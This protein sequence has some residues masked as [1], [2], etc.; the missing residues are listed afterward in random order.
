MQAV[1]AVVRRQQAVGI[2][3]ITERGV[4][5]H[6][7]VSE[8]AG[9]DVVVDRVAAW[10]RTRVVDPF[11][12][13]TGGRDR[14]DEDIQSVGAVVARLVQLPYS[15]LKTG[16]QIVSADVGRKAEVIDANQQDHV[17]DV[18]SFQHIGIETM[19]Q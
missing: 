18:G 17:A 16:D 4:E 10:G 6:D 1:A 15:L 9:S 12:G 19:Q 8:A 3:G 13:A 7:S 14:A 5:V 2:R 11:Y